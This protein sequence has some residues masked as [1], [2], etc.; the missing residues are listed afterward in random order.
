M[1]TLLPAAVIGVLAASAQIVPEPPGEGVPDP[2][3]AS[4]YAGWPAETCSS[5][6]NQTNVARGRE[7]LERREYQ[8]AAAA[9][10]LAADSCFFDAGV[11]LDYA[12]A[13]AQ[14]GALG[15]GED[16]LEQLA[17][18]NAKVP[19]ALL[20]IA[21]VQ[22]VV[23]Q[24]G[25]AIATV[26]RVLER[27]PAEPGALKIKA[28]ALY[29]SARD[30]EAKDALIR[31]IKAAPNDPEAP[32][33]LGRIYYQ[34]QLYQHA[35]PQF[36]R[37]LSLNARSYKA[38]DNL[39]LCYRALGESDKAAGY[40]LRAIEIAGKEKA[41]YGWAHSN[42]AELMI[43]Q[44][45]FDKAYALAFEAAELDPQGARHFFLA[46]RALLSMGRAE[47]SLR[48]LERAAEL[49]PADPASHYQLARALRQAGREADAEAAFERFR[50]IRENTP[51]RRR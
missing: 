41:A 40:F 45:E 6:E 36:E 46:G 18:R 31:A 17:Q 14:C 5:L 50:Q 7:L 27:Q 34:E 43:E 48:W 25:D 9:L 42:L 1:R 24:F 49:D 11:M 3:R 23:E 19:G 38:Y 22:L 44:G 15:D 30:D 2:S 51:A 29:L 12:R 20:A 28:N 32:Y 21:N 39:G 8:K 13:L 10:A 26:D 4:G 33:M 35:I 37:A 16:A 47:N